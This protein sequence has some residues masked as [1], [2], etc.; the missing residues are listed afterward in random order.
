MTI[1]ISKAVTVCCWIGLHLV[2]D[3]TVCFIENWEFTF[4]LNSFWIDNLKCDP[5][6]S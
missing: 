1:Q 3:S 6:Q 5:P 4:K 2:F